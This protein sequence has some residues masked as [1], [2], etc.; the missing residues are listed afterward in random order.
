MFRNR[1]HIP[2]GNIICCCVLLFWLSLISQ[3]A[4]AQTPNNHKIRLLRI[5]VVNAKTP[6]EK[7]DTLITLGELYHDAPE[8]YLDSAV[9]CLN[10]ALALS[11]QARATDRGVHCLKDLAVVYAKKQDWQASRNYTGRAV[12]WYLDRGDLKKA[13]D[14]YDYL[15]DHFMVGNNLNPQMIK[16]AVVFCDKKRK[17]YLKLKDTLDATQS[18]KDM[19]DVNLYIRNL[20]ST[21]NQLHRALK[22]FQK[23][24][25]K[26]LYEVYFL[27]ATSSDIRGDIHKELGYRL[28]I[29]SYPNA[30]TDTFGKY[31]YLGSLAH[32][33]EMMKDYDQSVNYFKKALA[34]YPKQRSIVGRIMD[35]LIQS[36]H[37]KEGIQFFL[38]HNRP[39]ERESESE[40]GYYYCNWGIYYQAIGDYTRAEQSYLRI[41]D[42]IKPDFLTVGLTS[43]YKV[44]N[45]MT[46]VRFYISIGNFKKAT[47]YLA[48]LDAVPIFTIRELTLAEIELFKFKADSGNHHY[49][50]ALRHFEKHQLILDTIFNFY[51]SGQISDLEIKYATAQKDKDIQLLKKQSIIE[52]A[53][54]SKRVVIT[55][56]LLITLILLFLLSAALFIGYR[57][58]QRN[59]KL[60]T[61]KQTEIVGKNSTLEQLVK[62][63]EWLV[64]EVHHRVKNNLQIIMSLLH[65]QSVFLKDEV[66]LNAVMDSQHRIQAMSLIHQKLY[67]EDVGTTIYMPEYVGELV[68]Y[69]KQSFKSGQRVI[70]GLT[71]EPIYFDVNIAVPLGLILNELIS[72]SLK[73]A[74]FPEKDGEITIRLSCPDDTIAHLF[75]GD[76]GRGLPPGFN[77]EN[78]KSFGIVL[79]KGLVENDLGGIF[80][81]TSDQGTKIKIN[82]LMNPTQ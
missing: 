64:R 71:I 12:Q 56:Y 39:L 45:Y 51:K 5:A 41:L 19:G 52:Q 53:K 54:E 79:V 33:Y 74:F 65:S 36:G 28:K 43:E 48:K 4:G 11:N 63:N 18:L 23:L 76:N 17:L 24:H 35:D 30:I 44:S 31:L 70:F 7:I 75:I 6:I 57:L 20:D 34:I 61:E 13:I 10:Q 2:P 1:S 22:E 9:R 69:L 55:G 72:N 8:K 66:A 67:K 59:I 37:K 38:T 78:T 27:L 73:Y 14:T 50:S 82:F 58:R 46:I 16:N 80:L 26:K 42:L 62:D 32:T 60:L 25:Y 3:N 15:C 49:F 81:I 77:V 68:G 29:Q 21:D 40:T 47:Y